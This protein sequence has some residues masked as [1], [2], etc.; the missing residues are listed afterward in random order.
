MKY[1]EDYI[2]KV[3][4]GNNIDILKKIS[5][6]SIDMVLT[7][8]PYWALRDYG[9]ENQLGL[10]S[11]FQEYID[12]LCDIFDEVKR[13]LKKDGTCWVNLGDTYF[14]SG[15][16]SLQKH[17]ENR[18]NKIQIDHFVFIIK[19]TTLFAVVR[20]T[21]NSKLRNS[22]LSP[23]LG[24]RSNWASTKPATISSSSGKSSSS[25]MFTVFMGVFP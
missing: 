1:P 6:E 3:I 16:K 14:G 21:I 11:T 25:S 10:E 2:N 24:I 8:P 20:S 15:K 5:N 18:S 7:S 17:K 4:C 12:K 13:I 22:N 9:V 23:D 19:L